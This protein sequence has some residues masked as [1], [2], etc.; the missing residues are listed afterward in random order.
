MFESALSK[1]RAVGVCLLVVLLTLFLIF[2]RIPKLDTVRADLTEATA[3]DQQCFQGFCV[4]TRPDTPLLTRWWETSVTY[5]RLV[6]L[7]MT[8]AF[9]VAGVTE[10]FLFP[11]GHS[12]APSGQ[13]LR[14]SLKGLII[15]P[16][17]N[18]CSACIV[19]ISAAFRGRGSSIETTLAIVHGSS[20][21]NLP[22]IIMAAMVFSPMIGGTRIA[23]SLVGAL[24]IGPLVA[25]VVGER[26]GRPTGLHVDVDPE[27][28][29]R[30]TWTTAIREGSRDWLRASLGYLIKLGPVMVL[31]GFASALVLQ[32]VS[33]DTVSRFL[34]DN[35]TGIAVA[36]TL[37]ILIN[38]PLLFEIPLVAALLLVGMGVGPAA[39]LLFTAA[40]GGPVT[41]WGLAKILPRRAVATLVTA[42]WTL[43]VVGGLA[44]LVIDPL[45]SEDG[46][47]GGTVAASTSTRFEAT[48]PNM[49]AAP[50][51]GGSLDSTVSER[52]AAA[53]LQEASTPGVPGVIASEPVDGIMPFTNI[54]P[55]ALSEGAGLL[56]Y[57]PAAV[58]FDFDRDGDLDFFLT[59]EVE[60][61]NFLYRNEGDGTFTNVSAEAGVAAVDSNSSGA[62]ACDID[63]DGFQDLYVGS[64]GLAY[65]GGLHLGDGLD[66][67]SALGDTPSSILDREA[68]TD[69][70]YLNNKDGTFRDIT[71]TAFGEDLNLR[72]ASSIACADVDNDG[73]LDI[74]VGNFTDMDF[75]GLD[76]PSH[77]GQFNLLYHNNGDLTFREISE[78]AGV[79]GG[80]VKLLDPEGRPVVFTDPDTGAEFQG[81]DPT[82]MDRLGNRIGDPS[83]RTLAVLFFDYD[84]DGDQD[85]WVADD[86]GRLH[87]YRNDSS[88]G[89]VRFTP[90]ADDVGVNG[91]GNW[92]G[93]AVGDYDG[94]QDLDVFVTNQGS[95]MRL[96]PPKEQVGGDCRY[97]DRFSWG[98]CMHY[99][100]R[101]DGTTDTPDRGTLGVFRDVALSTVVAPSPIMPPLALNEAN[102]DPGWP[103]PTGLGA[104]EFGYG[105]SFFDFDNDGHQDL[106]WLGSEV[107]RGEGPGGEIIESPGRMLR[108]DGS[109]GFE[110]ITV[111]ARL[112]DIVDV[113]YSIVDPT[114]P[115]FDAVRQR[116]SPSM[117][118]NGKGLAHGDISGDGYVDLIGT[119]SSG[120]V[121]VVPGESARP[122]EGNVFVWLNGGGDNHWITL[123]L[124]GRMGIDGT[125][126]NA[127]GVGARVNVKY[128]APGSDAPIV[129]VQE[130]R[131]G[132]SYLSMDSIDL[133][134]GL[135]AA[136]RVSEISIDWPSGRRQQITDV[137]ANQVLDIVEP[138]Q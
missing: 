115:G 134:F 101:N 122:A 47:S 108:G 38:V 64:R 130:V 7:G 81:Y 24:L 4:E 48:L 94:D 137:D 5:L 15:G 30:S 132:S 83:G 54:A 118:E 61:A 105:T 73:W 85:L 62:V 126:S 33:P 97:A 71:E 29:V 49:R 32:W 100:L 91:F 14:G 65:L 114:D 37:G 36:A 40:A 116:I 103:V 43:G 138:A 127:D 99:L 27:A 8:F 89:A 60:R 21:L 66:F 46:L 112:L 109:G 42:T 136:Q 113:D 90:V 50:E 123:R 84:T 74:Y 110:D 68:M 102:I 104:Y 12:R 16:A 45:I 9:L 98:T 56:N 44:V 19:P 87:L 52:P 1:K 111:R 25:A 96:H 69:R 80:Q 57:H 58:V 63:N 41:F 77:H 72:S 88:A 6:A 20:T 135:G 67:R 55:W 22:A 53:M 26:G 18:L 120:P 17:M 28:G 70:L 2:N 131:A 92:M 51:V 10:A 107:N 129:Q 128:Y 76:H 23:V 3:T 119:N 133:E 79:R 82:R 106:Y 86:G 93:F 78:T 35:L 31:A 13:G 11:S 34:G 117:H 39:T 121:W 75:H 59:S 125:G 124:Q 95:N